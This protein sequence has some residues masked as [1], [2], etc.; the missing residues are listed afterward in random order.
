M[1]ARGLR[2]PEESKSGRA[3]GVAL[4]E[5][6]E[7]VLRRQID[8]HHNWV[9]VHTESVKRNDG[10]TTASV[11]KMRVDSNT[12]WRAALK[13][14]GIDDFRFHDLRHTWASWLIQAGVPLSALQEMGGWESIE[15]VRRYAHL[16]PNHLTEHARKID[17]I[18]GTHD[19]NLAL[20][21]IGGERKKV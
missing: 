20:L 11:R 17:D 9:F 16:S 8:R 18:I 7:S 2:Y 13:R 14:A 1:R 21:E 4:N 19:T 3:I 12:A 6:A 5:M 10:T 15:M